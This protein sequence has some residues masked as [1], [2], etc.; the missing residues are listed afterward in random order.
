MGYGVPHGDD[1]PRVILAQLIKKGFSF[2][3]AQEMLPFA[4]EIVQEK[5][6]TKKEIE[7]RVKAQMKE[8]GYNVEEDE[9]D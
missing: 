7:R 6:A 8:E 4:T 1:D 9:N 3:E 2:E 5:M